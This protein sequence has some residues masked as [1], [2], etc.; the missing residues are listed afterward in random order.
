MAA[1][2]LASVGWTVAK[3]VTIG[4]A[5]YATLHS[6]ILQAEP[7]AAKFATAA[8]RFARGA[9]MYGGGA[10][11]ALYVGVVALAYTFQRKLMFFPTAEVR[12]ASLVVPWHTRSGAS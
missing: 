5:T 8:L 12:R 4:G 7:S 3:W 6:G 10:T 1:A 11:A 2:L 9:A